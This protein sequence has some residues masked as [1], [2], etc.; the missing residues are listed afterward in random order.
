MLEKAIVRAP[1]TG[2][3]AWVARPA[4]RKGAKGGAAVVTGC[5]R[6]AA[7]A[8]SAAVAWASSAR[9]PWSVA[10]APERDADEHEVGDPEHDLARG[11]HRHAE[12]DEEHRGDAHRP[13]MRGTA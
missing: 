5:V 6:P 10:N 7:S 12:D 8:A 4:P 11:E 13:D 2:D 9:R 1:A 3:R